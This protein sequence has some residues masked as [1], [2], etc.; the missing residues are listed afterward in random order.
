M[1]GG[2]YQSKNNITETQRGDEIKRIGKE[3]ISIHKLDKN[4]KK[5]KLEEILGVE[6]Y[7]KFKNKSET[8]LNV[9]EWK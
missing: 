7:K 4:R 1:H 5:S 3:I 6:E 8:K 9:D 2:H